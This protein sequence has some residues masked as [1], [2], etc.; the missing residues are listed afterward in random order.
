[1]KP[2]WGKVM[3]P[4]MHLRMAEL[5]EALALLSGDKRFSAD[6]AQK[7]GQTVHELTV[8]GD[9]VRLELRPHEAC[10]HFEDLEE[11]VEAV[12]ALLATEPGKRTEDGKFLVWKQEAGQPSFGDLAEA[13]RVLGDDATIAFA[14]EQGEQNSQALKLST[15]DIE[16]TLSGAELEV[17]LREE[18]QDFY[19][20][21]LKKRRFWHAF[22][23]GDWSIFAGMLF[24][25]AAG[26]LS[27]KLHQST[28]AAIAAVPWL[29]SAVWVLR[30]KDHRWTVLRS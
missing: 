5:N 20:A 1:M 6:D 11:R 2:Y 30:N 10:L 23:H 15:P 26:M 17:R 8:T 24:P 28:A 22:T 14:R 9:R 16:V 29:L 4:P 19:D 12:I 25:L 13:L 21:L 18:V 3:L 27:P 7:E